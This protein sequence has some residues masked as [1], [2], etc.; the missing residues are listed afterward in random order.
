MVLS[1]S[2]IFWDINSSTPLNDIN[3]EYSEKFKEMK[4]QAIK[5]NIFIMAKW[6]D[7]GYN[8]NT[9]ILGHAWFSTENYSGNIKYHLDVYALGSNSGVYVSLVVN[10]DASEVLEI[11]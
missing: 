11:L 2:P 10:S 3:S 7:D 4:Q 5:G 6:K 1:P 8:N 9:A